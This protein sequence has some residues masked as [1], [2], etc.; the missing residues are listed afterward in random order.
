M[1]ISNNSRAR[2]HSN[3]QNFQVW[4]YDNTINDLRLYESAEI[5]KAELTFEAA[6]NYLSKHLKKSVE[7]DFRPAF[8]GYKNYGGGYFG[9]LRIL[10]PTITFLGALYKGKDHTSN[11]VAFMRD[12]MGLINKKYEEIGDLIYYIF[13]HGLMHTQMPKVIN[14]DNVNV[15]WVITFNDEQHLKISGIGRKPININLSPNKLYKDLILAI[16]LYIQDFDNEL[17]KHHLLDSFKKGFIEMSKIFSEQEVRRKKC[18]RGV[19][20]IK[21]QRQ[22]LDM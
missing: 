2:N 5:W 7:R 17:K 10:F 19:N 1:G 14:I 18:N 11:A 4:A 8:I 12:Y 22:N 16:D 6:K 3:Q 20:Y 13:R 9:S 15:G 21:H